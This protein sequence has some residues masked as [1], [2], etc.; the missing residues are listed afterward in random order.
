[1]SETRSN[2]ENGVQTYILKAVHAD[3]DVV[4]NYYPDSM[5][6][7]DIGSLLRLAERTYKHIMSNEAAASVGKKEEAASEAEYEA[8][9]RKWRQNKREQIV[10]GE[11]TTRQVGPRLDPVDKEWLRL[12]DVEVLRPKLEGAGI[13]P[14]PTSGKTSI[15]GK[16]LNE[17]RQ[18]YK[19]SD[20]WSHLGEMARKNVEASRAKANEAKTTGQPTAA[21]VFGDL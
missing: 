15:L 5:S 6:G 3:Y 20:K 8:A 12:I 1:M 14:F 16:T 9:I 2:G 19:E 11:F 18:A 21:S 10:S 7:C 4:V 17:W 13:T